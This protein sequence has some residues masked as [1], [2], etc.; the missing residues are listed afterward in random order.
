MPLLY[1][2]SLY[3]SALTSSIESLSISIGRYLGFLRICSTRR[4][5]ETTSP[6]SLYTLTINSEKYLSP[7]DVYTH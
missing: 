3:T 7:L 4:T 6:L 2:A 5:V 1:T